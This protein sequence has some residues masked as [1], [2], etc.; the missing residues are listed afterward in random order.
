M[1]QR[2][3]AYMKSMVESS[4]KETL[5][6]TRDFSMKELDA[7]LEISKTSAIDHES[8]AIFGAT[9]YALH[10]FFLSMASRYDISKH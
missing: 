1:K 5:F 8:K 7:L 4:K 6:A 9:A 3:E 10:E 2:R